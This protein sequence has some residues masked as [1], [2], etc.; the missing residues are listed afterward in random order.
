MVGPAA[1]VSKILY[2]KN[3]RL[4]GEKTKAT[5][6][7]GSTNLF[8]GEIKRVLSMYSVPCD[9]HAENLARHIEHTSY[10]PLLLVISSI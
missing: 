7:R 8:C 9:F 10:T 4:Y 1:D 2:G 6:D 5:R 3:R